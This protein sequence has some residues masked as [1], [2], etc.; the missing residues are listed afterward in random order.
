MRVVFR[1]E[2]RAELLEARAWYDS[3]AAG[4]GLE[5][6]RAPGEFAADFVAHFGQAFADGQAGSGHRTA[7]GRREA[8][9][10]VG[11]Y[12]AAAVESRHADQAPTRLNL[13]NSALRA[14]GWPFAG[15]PESGSWAELMQAHPQAQPARVIEQHRSGYVVAD[16][17]DRS[18]TVESPPEWQRP[19][20]YRKG[21]VAPEAR[22]VVGDWVLVEDGK[23]IVAMLPRH[24]AMARTAMVC[25]AC[26]AMCLRW[27]AAGWTA[28]RF[29]W[30]AATR[31]SS[32]P[33]TLP[34]VAQNVSQIDGPR[35][36]RSTP[37]SIWYDE[38]ETPHTKSSGRSDRR[39]S[40]TWR[41][42]RRGRS[43][44]W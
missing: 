44:C 25:S 8:A 29:R 32:P 9:R 14:I 41:P 6:A 42:A 30:S 40:L 16:A 13:A 22:A 3:R 36:S 15:M 28:M 7:R 38:V 21:K 31:P 2:A 33:R 1:P 11:S 37:P 10:N 19:P 12:A 5:F 34:G 23:R 27:P 35:P 26:R 24:S 17:T 39:G 20:G 18:F 4:L 43:R